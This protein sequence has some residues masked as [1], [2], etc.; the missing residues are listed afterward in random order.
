MSFTHSGWDCQLGVPPQR[1]LAY[2]LT[3]LIKETGIL[4]TPAPSVWPH[5]HR[6]VYPVVDL[7]S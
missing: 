3:P 1:S 6:L 5:G 4:R 2:L 7:A